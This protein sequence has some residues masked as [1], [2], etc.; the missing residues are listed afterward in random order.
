M[1]R[2]QPDETSKK[3]RTKILFWEVTDRSSWRMRSFETTAFSIIKCQVSSDLIRCKMHLQ[4]QAG[5][6]GESQQCVWNGMRPGSHRVSSDLIGSHRLGTANTFE[7]Q[8]SLIHGKIVGKDSIPRSHQDL[9]SRLIS[10]RRA[11]TCASSVSALEAMT[12][13]NFT[14]QGL[15]C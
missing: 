1:L 5:Y 14:T 9:I 8:E 10:M 13:D 3:H 12:C 2:G 6:W 4:I 15:N 11:A 7:S